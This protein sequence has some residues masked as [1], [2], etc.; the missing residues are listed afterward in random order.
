MKRDSESG[1]LFHTPFLAVL[2][3]SAP[4]PTVADDRNDYGDDSSRGFKETGP[5]KKGRPKATL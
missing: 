1:N 2:R 5:N 4:P 3:N